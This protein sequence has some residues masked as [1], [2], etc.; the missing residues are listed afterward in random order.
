[1]NLTQVKL[2]HQ[3]DAVNLANKSGYSNAQDYR[4]AI[5][6]QTSVLSLETIFDNGFTR[7][8][9]NVLKGIEYKSS[10]R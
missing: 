6:H 5:T 4:Y 3:A 8:M 10:T 7:N 2:N 9:R 1:L